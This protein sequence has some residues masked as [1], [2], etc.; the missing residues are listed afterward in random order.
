MSQTIQEKN[1]KETIETIQQL[2]SR[3]TSALRTAYVRSQLQPDW[4]Y[5]L[6]AQSIGQ[7]LTRWVYLRQYKSFVAKQMNLLAEKKRKHH[8]LLQELE[9]NKKVKTVKK[10]MQV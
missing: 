6:S 9:E 4:I 2:E 3:L 1:K 7:A 10:R 5:L 8:E